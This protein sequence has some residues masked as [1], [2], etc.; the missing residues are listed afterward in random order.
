MYQTAGAVYK[1]IFWPLFIAMGLW[2][3]FII[4]GCEPKKPAEQIIDEA[5]TPEARASV[6]K[7]QIEHA[8]QAEL[9]QAWYPRCV[10]TV[11][12]GFLSDFSYD[13]QPDGQQNKFIVSQARQVWTA[14]KAAERYPDDLRYRQAADHGF[15]FLKEY[16]WDKEHGGFFEL[17]NQQGEPV[18]AEKKAYGNSF[19]IYGL[20]AY[21]RLTQSDEALD[22]AKKAFQW[23]DEHAHDPLD[24][25]Y[26]QFMTR[27]GTPYA[28]NAIGGKDS[29]LPAEKYK[30]Q[31]SSIHL[32]EAFTE[33]YSVWPDSVLRERLQEMLELIRD[34]Q[35]RDF[36]SLTL[37]SFPDWQPVTFADSSRQYI[38]AHVHT[39]HVSFGHDI[40]TGF[41]LIEAS[42]ALGL[43]HDEK[44]LTIAK[45]MVDHSIKTGWDEKNGG[46]FNGG[47]YFKGS[48]EIEIVL[49]GKDWWPQSEAMNALLLFSN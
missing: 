1:R 6:V 12:G 30:D 43:E 3:V 38:E 46:L 37:F 28:S 22:W 10:D 21:A 41:L 45:K 4:T 35:V 20:A 42:E 33:L 7:A 32:L 14:C 9:L 36:G 25:G 23:L 47:Y 29:G 5:S 2:N 31:N 34:V 19:G 13:W 8:L 48:E 49:P 24:G 18:D 26:Y 40:E 39:D 11:Y 16:M 27:E 15:K 44:T 17:V